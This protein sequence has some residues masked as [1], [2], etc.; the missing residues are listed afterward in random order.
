M[1][2]RC[3]WE[4]TLASQ[5]YDDRLRA[6]RKPIHA[7]LGTKVGAA[8]FNALQEIEVH[9]FLLRT[10]KRPA[11]LLDHI[12]TYVISAPPP[13]LNLELTVS[14]RGRGYNIEVGLWLHHR[15]TRAGPARGYR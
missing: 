9:R 14:Q 5:L 7:T 11:G 3:G 8:R 1:I 6:Y 4:F 2:S 15:A 13:W 12:R 10:L